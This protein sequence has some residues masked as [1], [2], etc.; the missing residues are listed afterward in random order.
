MYLPNPSDWYSWSASPNLAP[1][2]LL[3]RLPRTW[4]AVAEC[5]LLAPEALELAGRLEGLGV[6]VER[7]VVEG[8][9]HSILAL[10]GV[11]GKGRQLVERAV[12]AVRRGF[13]G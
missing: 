1:E 4:I 9:T 10:N 11:L 7:Y 3:A 8:G 5:D 12:E 2:E 13:G 6:G